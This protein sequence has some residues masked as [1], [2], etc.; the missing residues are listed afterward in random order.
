M[1]VLLKQAQDHDADEV[2]DVQAIGGAVEADIGSDRTSA[3]G[4]IQRVEVGALMDEATLGGFLEEC[5]SGHD[6]SG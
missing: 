3:Q 2:A 6:A 4:R 1:A 5:A